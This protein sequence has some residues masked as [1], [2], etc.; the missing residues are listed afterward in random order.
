MASRAPLVRE[1]DLRRMAKVA[2]EE[3]V[4]IR[5]RVD[6]MGGFSFTIDAHAPKSGGDD[7]DLDARIAK[8]K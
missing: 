5:G 2:R 4:S 8:W 7:V 3:G 1:A 6:A